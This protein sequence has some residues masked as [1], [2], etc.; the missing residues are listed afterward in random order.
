MLYYLWADAAQ[1]RTKIEL[2][3]KISRAI[4]TYFKLLLLLNC[5]VI[6]GPLA[7]QISILL[8]NMFGA[9]LTNL[10]IL[11]E[12]VDSFLIPVGYIK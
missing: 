3:I 4:I 1:S 5:L 7:I 2:F 11:L 8:A 10:L 9:G 6:C 12:V